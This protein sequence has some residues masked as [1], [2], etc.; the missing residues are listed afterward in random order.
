ME[1]PL[2]PICHV[3]EP[4][5]GDAMEE[6]H[7]ASADLETVHVLLE[8]R[9]NVSK[10]SPPPEG[11]CGQTCAETVLLLTMSPM[12]TIAAAESH[13]TYSMG[14]SVICRRARSRTDDRVVS[15]LSAH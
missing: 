15:I 12:R 10:D 3:E 8:S 13:R 7:A 9:K 1:R 2:W 14:V 5:P 11:L 4:F 6:E